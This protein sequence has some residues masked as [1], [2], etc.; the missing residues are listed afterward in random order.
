VRQ[1]WLADY[2]LCLLL[3]GIAQIAVAQD[4]A[5]LQA[6]YA[7]LQTQLNNNWF[8]QPLYLQSSEQPPLLQGDIYARI[9]QPFSA[10][11][12]ALLGIARWCEILLLHLNVKYCRSNAPA[13]DS[14]SVGIGRK[15]EQSSADAKLV[16]FQ[17]RVAS[18]ALDYQQVVLKAR[19]GPLGTSDYRIVLEVTSVDRQRS[20][21][22]L[23]YAYQYGTAARLAMQ[24]YLATVGRNKIG[25]TRVGTQ[26]NGQPRY[27]NGQRGVVERN[28]MRYYLAIVAYL[29][30][31]TTPVSQQV[32]KRLNDWFNS[33]EKY[34]AQLH[35]LTRQQYLEMKHR[36]MSGD[37]AVS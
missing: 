4:A 11:G 6:R 28:T 15:F 14:I 23:S 5:A 32:D 36:E 27:I 31:L 29:G 3:L 37:Q 18:R 7:A 17:Y 30:T 2:L 19:K 21:L 33:I 12:P 26:T 24:G 8:N 10:A 9:D 13:G 35:E 16:E 1:W 34:P 25:F 22:H 20:F